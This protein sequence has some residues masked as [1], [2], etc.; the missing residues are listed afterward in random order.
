MRSTRRPTPRRARPGT[1]AR[2]PSSASPTRT[3]TCSS[4][5]SPPGVVVHPARGNR[6]GT[7]AQALAGTCRRRRGRVARRHRPPPR[8]R[9]ARAAGRREV[10]ARPPRA[11]GRAAAPRRSRASTSRSSRAARR[12]APGRSTRRS[13]ATAACARGCRPTPTQPREARHALRARARRCRATTL[14]RVR[15]ETGP[16]PPDPRPPAGDRPSRSAATPSTA[17]AG[18][19]GL[20]RQFLHAARLAFAHPVTGEAVDIASQLPA[21]LAAALDLARDSRA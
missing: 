10:R 1:P 20:A 13:A 3:S 16:H 11:E 9:H 2:P 4:S 15:L 7:L 18:R 8:P 17:T 14:L 12:R 5:T 19:F 6:T 21:D